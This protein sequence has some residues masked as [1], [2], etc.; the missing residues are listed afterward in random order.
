MAHQTVKQSAPEPGDGAQDDSPLS[1]TSSHRKSP[2]SLSPPKDQGSVGA[3]HFEHS[4]RGASPLG[5]RTT[6][7]ENS[8]STSSVASPMIFGYPYQNSVNGFFAPEQHAPT[9]IQS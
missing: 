3:A 8:G 9:A 2:N 6:S 1:E 4:P 5:S 7:A